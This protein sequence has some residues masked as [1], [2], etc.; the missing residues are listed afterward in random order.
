MGYIDLFSFHCVSQDEQ[1]NYVLDESP[2]GIYQFALDLQK[3]GKIKHIGFSTHG[4]AETILRMINSEKFSYVNIH[5]HYF[6]DYHAAGTPDMS[7]GEGNGAAVK[8]ALE[9]DM[10]VFLISPFDKGGKLFR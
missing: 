4:S 10:G 6:G 5:K 9:L 2:D 7:G 1:I 3:E 8:R